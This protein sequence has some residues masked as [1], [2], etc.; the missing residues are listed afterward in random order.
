MAIG[1]DLVLALED[2]LD[3]YRHGTCVSPAAMHARVREMY[4]WQDVAE[5]T[6]KASAYHRRGIT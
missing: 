1:T 6:E 4:K 3:R 5:R 2:V